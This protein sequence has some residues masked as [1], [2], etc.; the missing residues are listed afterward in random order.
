MAYVCVCQPVTG[1][2]QHMHLELSQTVQ[3]QRSFLPCS[4]TGRCIY[5]SVCTLCHITGNGLIVFPCVC[6][7]CRSFQLL[8]IK[9]LPFLHDFFHYFYAYK[10]LCLGHNSSFSNLSC[11]QILTYIRVCF[12]PLVYQN[13]NV[14]LKEHCSLAHIDMTSTCS[15]FFFQNVLTI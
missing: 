5:T 10:L 12:N 13:H 6:F 4:P 8:C 1:H 2:M 15:L 11:Y 14:L 3:N 9:N 7:Y